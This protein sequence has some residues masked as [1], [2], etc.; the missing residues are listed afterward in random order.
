MVLVRDGTAMDVMQLEASAATHQLLVGQHGL[1]E[2]A[3]SIS[4]VMNSHV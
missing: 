1:Q 4:M 2:A 3:Q